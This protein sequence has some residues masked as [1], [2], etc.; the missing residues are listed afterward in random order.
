MRR[1]DAALLLHAK[2]QPAGGSDPKSTVLRL[3]ARGVCRTGASGL[4]DV[5]LGVA[6]RDKAGDDS[7]EAAQGVLG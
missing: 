5:G 3:T 6:D 4:L 2:Q 7:E 1:P